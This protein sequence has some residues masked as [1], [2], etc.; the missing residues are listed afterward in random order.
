VA[1]PDEWLGRLGELPLIH[2]PGRAWIYST[3]ADV[4]GVLV[5]RATGQP[6]ETFLRDRLFGPLGMRDTGFSVPAGDIGRLATSR[7]NDFQSGEPIVY[8]E[9]AGG[10]WSSPPAFPSAAGGLVSTMSDYYAFT[11]MLRRR[12]RYD[13]GRILS[14]P[15]VELMTSDQLTADQK[16]AADELAPGSFG[17]TGWGFCLSV[18]TR[19]TG[20]RSAGCYGWDGGLGTSWYND[21]AEDMTMI[22]MTQQMWASPAEP[23]AFADFW[24]LAYQAIDD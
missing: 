20:F 4:L 7:G 21:P 11:D 3:G 22:L 15:S 12:G 13:A 1:A 9:A 2:Q 24:T 16:A 8:D 19:R 17:D 10:Q 6:L 5:A 18:V 14:R 23:P